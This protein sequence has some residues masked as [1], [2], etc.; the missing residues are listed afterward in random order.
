MIS[1]KVE[2]L[3]SYR[4]GIA[5][6]DVVGPCP[7][8]VRFNF[9]LTGGEVWGPRL[10]GKVKAGGGDFA[11]LRTDG[12]IVLDVRGMLESHDGALIDIAYSGVIDLGPEGHANFLK[13]VM[14]TELKA[15]AAP[16]LRV[17]HPAY[18][19][20]NRLQCYSIGEANLA[21][22]EITYDVYALI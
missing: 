15:C 5:A 6:P 18:Q 21:R 4:S 17:A 3:F 16:R 20:L 12:V 7:A 8:D 22:Q 2:H 14:P 13:G 10:T 9:A 19:W 1:H 11:T